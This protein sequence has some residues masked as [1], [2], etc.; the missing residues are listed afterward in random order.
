MSGSGNGKRV[1]AII[2]IL[3]WFVF[4]IL[5]GLG[6][7]GTSIHPFIGPIPFS[8]FYLLIIGLWGVINAIIVVKVFS[9]DFYRKAEE[10]QQGK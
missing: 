2:L 4:A 1:L 8:F 5:Q 9:Q 6:V 10:I 7:L 3:V